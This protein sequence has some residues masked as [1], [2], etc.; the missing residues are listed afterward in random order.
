MRISRLLALVLS[1]SCCVGAGSVNAAA[2][3]SGNVVVFA[4]TSMSNALQEAG[5]VYADKTG[6]TITLTSGGVVALT[7][8]I[9]AGERADV[10]IL[11]DSQEAMDQLEARHLID[12]ATRHD[13]INNRL[14]LI[15]AK[16]DPIKLYITPGFPLAAALGKGRLAIGRPESAAGRYTR[17]ALI[18]L[19]AW[20]SVTDHLTPVDN[21]RAV[22]G[23]VESGKAS[24]GV[25]Y[26]SDAFNQKSVRIVDVFPDDAL[27]QISFAVALTKPNAEAARFVAFLRSLDGEAV[28]LRH[29]FKPRKRL[30]SK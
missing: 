28:F 11:G 2:S 7:R 13:L 29:G 20:N 3:R 9:E 6:Q 15:A 22:L 25:V 24:L 30:Q 18:A 26:E 21:T 10:I 23:L 12:A 4:A 1:T 19:G 14:V 16:D 27:P 5:K 17:Y 8:R